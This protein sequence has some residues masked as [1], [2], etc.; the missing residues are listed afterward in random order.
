MRLGPFQL[1]TC[2]NAFPGTGL[3]AKLEVFRKRLPLLRAA[4]QGGLSQPFA[5]G[6]W[7]D[8]AAVASIMKA[9]KA[10]DFAAML[11]AQGVYA[12]TANAFP[13]GRFHDGP[14]KTE[15]YK[16]DWSSS[17]RLEFTCAVAEILKEALP[18]GVE[19][20][21]STLP[22]A[23]RSAFKEKDAPALR[24]NLIETGRHLKRIFKSSGRRI[25]LAVEMEPDCLWEAP[26]EFCDYFARNLH[27]DDAS[28]FIGVCYDTCHQELLQTRPGQGFDTFAKAGVKIAKVQ[29]SAAI[30]A[31]DAAS[32][33][34]L[35]RHFQDPVYLHQT[36][37]FPGDGSMI[38]FPDLPEALASKEREKPWKVHFHV[39]V[40]IEGMEGG[41]LPAKDELE[42]AIARLAK[43]PAVCSNIEIETYSYN[44]LPDFSKD[45]ASIE[46]GM[47]REI[48]W[49]AA[50]L[51]AAGMKAT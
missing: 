14:V 11:R 24:A 42:A 35:E 3:D 48:E 21:I 39:P 20:S 38:R 6:L 51:A 47:A 43:E 41:L 30:A 46:A 40:F 36:R 26:E 13:F 10:K 23:Y 16:P 7:L 33:K 50:K 8:A 45:G 34:T 2:L 37:A 44:V 12:F 19:G 32:K 31:P 5:A 29:L 4:V 15:V 1:C 17:E 18:E 27:D 25:T 28:E 22:A 9:R 49:T